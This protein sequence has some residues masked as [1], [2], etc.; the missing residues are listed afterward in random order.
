MNSVRQALMIVI[1]AAT[2]STFIAGCASTKGQAEAAVAETV[3]SPTP[4]LTDQETPDAAAKKLLESVLKGLADGDYAVYSRD[5]SEKHK[6]FFT[7]A[8]FDES[9]AWM[10]DTFGACESAEFMGFW[11]R[12]GYF[13]ALWKAKYSKVKDDDVILELCFKKEGGSYKV[14]AFKPR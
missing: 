4:G 2:C 6:E 11:K 8:N 5:F 7:K 13:L 12:R 14:E 3:A 1:V 10:K 9:A